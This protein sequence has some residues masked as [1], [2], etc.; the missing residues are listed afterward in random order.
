VEKW[1]WREKHETP[2]DGVIESVKHEV[3][4]KAPPSSNQK[5]NQDC[6]GKKVDAEKRQAGKKFPRN[7]AV[8]NQGRRETSVADGGWPGSERVTHVNRKRVKQYEHRQTRKRK[9][10]DRCA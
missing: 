6:C 4:D 9:D 7:L 3:N 1:G 5:T 2:A 8:S 10:N